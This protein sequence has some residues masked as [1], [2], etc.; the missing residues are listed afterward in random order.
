M[1]KK[2]RIDKLLVARGLVE[3]R[4]KAQALIMAGIVYADNI[5][6]NKPG[7]Q[8][9]DEINLAIKQKSHPWVSR[10]GVKLEHGLKC[11]SVSIKDKI[12]IDLGSSTG[13]FTDVLLVNGAKK[14]YAIDVGKGQLDWRLRNDDRVVVMEGQNARYISEAEI[15]D[16]PSIIVCDASFIGLKKILPATLRLAAP[17]AELIALIKPQFEVG[18]GRV[19]KGGVVRDPRLHR[20]VCCS[21][22]QWLSK[23][24]G[25]KVLG[26][27]QSPIEGPK[28]NIEFLICATQKL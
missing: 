3:N 25:W 8:I 6:L 15:P 9:S 26:V 5:R 24:M 22:S 11:F 2:E 13:G 18:K 14:V 10:G 17:N 19:G 21:I 7:Q 28:G 1:A 27:E 4:A 16:I 12:C 23:E 20:E